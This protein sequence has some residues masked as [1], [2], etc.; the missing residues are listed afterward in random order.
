MLKRFKEDGRNYADHFLQPFL[1]ALKKI[2][3]KTKIIK[4]LESYQSGK[5]NE[6]YQK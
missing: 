5:F 6:M 3:V 4:N 1:Q 2:D